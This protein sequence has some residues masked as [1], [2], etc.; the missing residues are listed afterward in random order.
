MSSF[1]DMR[2]GQFHQRHVR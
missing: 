1:S 2:T